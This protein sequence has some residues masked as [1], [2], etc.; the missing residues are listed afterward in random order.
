MVFSCKI[1]CKKLGE[2]LCDG[3]RLL[4]SRNLRLPSLTAWAH[5]STLKTRIFGLIPPLKGSPNFWH[6]ILQLGTILYS[7]HIVPGR[8]SMKLK[9]TLNLPC[10]MVSWLMVL[11]RI[12]NLTHIFSG[13]RRS[14]VTR[15]IHVPKMW[16][17]SS[18]ATRIPKTYKKAF[19]G[20]RKRR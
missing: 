12:P 18:V 3:I 16:I 14:A 4:K 11:V 8:Q 5:D 15:V 13:E 6:V 17:H 7:N 20:T 1:T 10:F 19:E 9:K 2:F